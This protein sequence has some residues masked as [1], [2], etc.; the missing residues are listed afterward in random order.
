[1]SSKEPSSGTTFSHHQ[2]PGE[3]I[4]I[5]TLSDKYNF[6]T[7]SGPS[8]QAGIKVLNT[9]STPV[10]WILDMRHLTVDLELLMRGAAVTARDS[11]SIYRHPMVRE[12][13]FVFPEVSEV[14]QLGAK[15]LNSEAFGFIKASVMDSVDAAIAY[16]RSKL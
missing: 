3:P 15:G 6:S 16:A 4:V 10:F 7:D 14:L 11:S 13:I 1:M 12:V 2:L 8:S 5:A 9:M